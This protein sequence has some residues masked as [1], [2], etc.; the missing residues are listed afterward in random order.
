MTM[1]DYKAVARL[2]LENLSTYHIVCLIDEPIDT[3]RI[4]DHLCN[5]GGFI[6][7]DRI[8]L[9]DHVIDFITP[10]RL[11]HLLLEYTLLDLREQKI[12]QV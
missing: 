2:I 4:A 8:S 7:Y 1:Y 10:D 9:D 5:K 11:D 12:N 6:G 3:A